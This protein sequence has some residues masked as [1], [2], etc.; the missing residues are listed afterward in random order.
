MATLTAQAEKILSQAKQL[1][2]FISSNNLQPPSFERDTLASLPP[3]YEAT[4]RELID[5]T[6]ALK[7]LAQGVAGATTEILYSVCA[8]CFL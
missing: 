4:R 8:P 1:D 2:A 3:Q 6:Q 5:S 7:R